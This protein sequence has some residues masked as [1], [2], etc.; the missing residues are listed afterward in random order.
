VNGAIDEDAFIESAVFEVL[1][2]KKNADA[3]KL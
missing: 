2:M 1:K 3:E